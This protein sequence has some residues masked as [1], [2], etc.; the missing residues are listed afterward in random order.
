MTNDDIEF[1]EYTDE[2]Y[3][4]M[5]GEEFPEDKEYPYECEFYSDDLTEK[6]NKLNYLEACHSFYNQ[7]AYV[8]MQEIPN[9]Y[10]EWSR[11]HLKRSHFYKSHTKLQL[12]QLYTQLKLQVIILEQQRELSRWGKFKTWLKHNNKTWMQPEDIPTPLSVWE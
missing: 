8:D 2:E 3:C 4:E 6:E 9:P 10:D 11:R 5:L 1:P 12:A 7:Y